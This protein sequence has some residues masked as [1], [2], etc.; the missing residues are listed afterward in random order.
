[1]CLGYFNFKVE[2][3]PVKLW[4]AETSLARQNKKYFDDNFNPF[5][6]ITQLI[7]EP[8]NGIEPFYDESAKQN[9]TALQKKILME[10]FE[11]YNKI[12]QIVAVCDTC[13]EE[14][15][16][17]LED[18][19]FQP[20]WPENQNCATQA[21]FQYWQNDVHKIRE[22]IE[23]DQAPNHLDYCMKNP[24]AADCL[25]SFGG[26][27]QPYMVAGSYHG[28]EYLKANAL[29]ITYVIKN[30]K[31][32]NA[33]PIKKAMAWESE[34]LQLLQNYSS[35]LIDISYTT[36]RSIEDELERESKAD[37]K[38]IAISY[39][40]M[41]AYLTVTLGKYSSL[42]FRVI[43][44]EMKI[45]LALA[46]VTLV[47]LSVFSSGGFFTYLGVPATLITLEVIPFLLLAVG[48][49]NIYVMVQTYQND[50]RLEFESVEDQIAR[51]VGKVGPSM[52]LTGTTQ[53]AAFLISAMTP[54][55]GVRAFSLYASLAIILNFIMQITCF[56][57]LLTL[58]AK[59]EQAKRIDILCCFKLKVNESEINNGQ[60]S[61]LH[62]YFKD[63][64]TPFLFNDYVRASVIIIFVGFFFACISMCDKIK[65]GLDQKLAMPSDSYQIKY[66]EALQKHLKVGPPV[67]FVLKDGY[68]YSDTNLLRLLCGSSSC[69]VNSMQSI[70]SAASVFPNETYIAQ[71]TVNWIDDY[72]EWLSAD[73]EASTSETCCYIHKNT[74]KFCDIKKYNANPKNHDPIDDCI[75]CPV[76]RTSY[77][78]PTNESL[79][80]YLN[81]FLHQNPSESCVKAGHAMYGNAVKVKLDDNQHKVKEIKASHF[82]AYHTVLS[83]SD[84][85]INAMISA[86]Q[87]SDL[88][89]KILN[90]HSI[91]TNDTNHKYE[92]IPYSIFYVFYEQYVKIW[93]DA[94]AQLLLTLVAIFICTFILLSFDLFTSLIVTG[95]IAIIIIDMV[96]IMYLWNIEL[97]AI[98][99]VNLVIAIG[100]SVEFSSHIA[101][102]FATSDAKNKKQR[103][104]EAL[105]TMGPPVF[106]GVLQSIVGISVLAFAHSQLFQV[107]YFRMY[108]SILVLGLTHGLIFLPV[109]L[110]YIG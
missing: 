33:E 23:N 75:P 12:N 83:T 5:Y 36:E 60:K 32:S 57:V 41:F 81:Y 104:S 28:E 15:I 37:I 103:A 67:Y 34:V 38:I 79:L 44:L 108:F 24:Y 84:D 99:L 31:K 3:D 30:Y 100:I 74:N 50:Q 9:I 22:A 98:S 26:P 90:N 53:S 106:S 95:V 40:I 69:D 19:C 21:L 55:P 49:D 82:M 16:V 20:L 87:I 48:V 73:P 25:S 80:T 94:T 43:L 76:N 96:G 8:K 72:M 56:V 88:I 66:F 97:N 91:S 45:C 52:L 58:D 77:K 11:L 64:Y 18:I 85:F 86:N 107:F 63:I 71:S 101:R 78:F 39:L 110:S 1:M 4:S 93:Q 47:L 92:V 46:G 105:Y 102:A 7:I 35:N 89:N 70:I 61:F 109:L 2:K 42:N 27:I 6:R 14:E 65:I 68:N 59:R 51:I 62:R 17:K 10:T 54:M 29:V 13:E